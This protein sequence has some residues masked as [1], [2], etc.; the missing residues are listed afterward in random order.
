MFPDGRQLCSN[1][2]GEG[3]NTG[4]DWHNRR[5]PG[6]PRPVKVKRKVTA[7]LIRAAVVKHG[8]IAS[9]VNRLGVCAAGKLSGVVKVALK[10]LP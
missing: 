6:R 10:R 8:R 4:L 7:V 1:A 2:A 9:E 5:V 3:S